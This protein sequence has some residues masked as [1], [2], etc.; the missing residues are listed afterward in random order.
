MGIE[1]FFSHELPGALCTHE[2]AGFLSRI[3][4]QSVLLKHVFGVVALAQLAAQLADLIA[5]SVLQTFVTV[6]IF[7][8]GGDVKAN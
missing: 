6:E 2:P 1:A 3:L 5:S 4:S 7:Y 8:G